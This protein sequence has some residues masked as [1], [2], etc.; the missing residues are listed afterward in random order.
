LAGALLF[1][2]KI[3]QSAALFWFGFQDVG[4]LYLKAVI[5]R[6]NDVSPAFLEHG[7]VKKIAFEH[8]QT[9]IQTSTGRRL[10]SF[11]HEVAQIFELLFKIQYLNHKPI[12]VDVLFKA[13][14][15]VPLSCRFNLAGQY[16]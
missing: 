3:C 10:D 14:Q 8:L 12:A 16:L 2:E 15:M 11:L 5:Q 13:Y 7:S 6:T 4:I 9:V 1:D